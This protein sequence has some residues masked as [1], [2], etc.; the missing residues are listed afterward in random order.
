M[1]EAGRYHLYVSLDR[2]FPTHQGALLR[3]PQPSVTRSYP[4][5]GVVRY[6]NAANGGGNTA[7][8]MSTAT[9]A[10]TATIPVGQA[11]VVRTGPDFCAVRLPAK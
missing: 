3:Q 4:G 2:Q 1:A 10:V 11:P 8:V 6:P 9:N 5:K 7:S